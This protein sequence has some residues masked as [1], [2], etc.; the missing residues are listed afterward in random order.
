MPI[1]ESFVHNGITIDIKPTPS[2]MGPLG[3]A[4]FG[5]VGTAPDADPQIP[6]NKPYYI[7]D[8]AK[9]AKLDM[10]GTERG[11]L[12]PAINAIYKVAQVSIYVVIVEED[13]ASQ[14]AAKDY[15][16][17]ITSA[18]LEEGTGYLRIVVSQPTLLQ[19]VVG[20]Q[21]ASWTVQ[22]DA[23]S[24]GMVS[25]VPGEENVLR[26]KADGTLKLADLTEGVILTIKG[27]DLTAAGT[28]AN[29][30]G[31]VDP[32][33]GRRTGIEALAAGIPE[34]LTDIS[35]PGFTHKAVHDAVTAMAKRLFCHPVLEGP[36][37]TDEAAIA[38]SQSLGGSGLGYENAAMADPY[39][40]VWS[41]ATKGYV[42]ASAA[43]HYLSCLARIH[44]HEAPGKGRMGVMIDGLQREID[45]SIVDKTSGGNRL[46][47]YGICYFARTS[48]GGYSLIGNRCITG[49]F[50][51]VVRT[52][53]A[54]VRKL[55]ATSEIAMAELLS[56]EFMEQRV[57]LL[58]SGLSAEAAAGKFIGVQVYLHPVMNNAE[59]Y[60]NG[61]WHI[62]IK[63]AAY[64]PNE[65]MVY[66][67]SED[68]G[69]L[70]NFLEEIL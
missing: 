51:N 19:A 52:E 10:T 63:W 62:C 39:P 69:I 59:N 31:G 57:A 50:I 35:A 16:A 46:N 6:R 40:K 24:A 33:S 21:A 29:V 4:V 68:Q 54:I 27:K 55:M 1:I 22:K 5:F 67:L 9:L 20:A 38:M 18:A 25:F 64:R 11:T 28:I 13:T 61:E 58:N 23:K 17:T 14:P 66:H 12:W 45:Y 43:A 34:T 41:N 36:S 53:L 42:Y 2:P 44:I 26:I 70:D 47:K 32:V 37:T 65:H 48:L 60:N 56:K 30:I 8:K 15:Q 7:N 3:R 49:R